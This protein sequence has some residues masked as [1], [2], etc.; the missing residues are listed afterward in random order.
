MVIS[1]V[2]QSRRG[3][4]DALA[5]GEVVDGEAIEPV[6]DEAPSVFLQR[7]IGGQRLDSGVADLRAVFRS[8]EV[9]DRRALERKCRPYYVCCIGSLVE[10]EGAIVLNSCIYNYLGVLRYGFGQTSFN[11][12]FYV[13]GHAVA[14]ESTAFV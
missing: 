13:T 1:T 4:S 5:R 8:V 6:A 14:G 12:C 3:R 11:G 9:E 10:L 2:S 7:L